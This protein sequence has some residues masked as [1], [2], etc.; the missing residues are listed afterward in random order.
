MSI[1]LLTD[2]GPGVTSPTIDVRP[3]VR[4]CE[5]LHFVATGNFNAAIA[6][7]GSPTTHGPEWIALGTLASNGATLS[8]V[9]PWERVRART[10]AVQN[11]LASVFL[12]P[13]A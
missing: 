7:E 10:S 2:A 1:S 6:I 3:V 4:D 11:G 9:V 13:D 8:V 5:P 12:I